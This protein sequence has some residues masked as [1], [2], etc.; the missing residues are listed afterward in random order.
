MSSLH[1]KYVQWYMNMA[2]MTPA[3]Y[4]SA[5]FLSVCHTAAWYFDR[6]EMVLSLTPCQS[7]ES[8]PGY[9]MLRKGSLAEGQAVSSAAALENQWPSFMTLPSCI[10][11]F[12][13]GL[14]HNA[15]SRD[16]SQTIVLLVLFDNKTT[17]LY[18][19]ALYE[20]LFKNIDLLYI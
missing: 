10:F 16:D 14:K 2:I 18:V 7:E 4:F 15:V 3:L 8:R 17:R 12:L 13:R 1:S 20:L 9:I 5:S 11:W 6:L 19:E